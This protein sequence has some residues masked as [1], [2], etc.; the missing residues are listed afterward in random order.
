MTCRSHIYTLNHTHTHAHTLSLTHL[1]L[2]QHHGGYL[3]R[4]KQFVLSLDD[5][6]H[7]WLVV[8]HL[9]RKRPKLDVLLHHGVVPGSPD[10]P[11]SIKH[12]VLWVGCQLVL[13]R[14]SDEPLS[15]RGEGHIGGSDT[16]PLVIGD[17]VNSSILVHTNTKGEEK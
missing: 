17:N 2:D 9:C 14:V 11:L 6:L 5:H 12:S 16:I 3:F 13:G 15:I 4:S 1:H 8:L 10:E 7:V